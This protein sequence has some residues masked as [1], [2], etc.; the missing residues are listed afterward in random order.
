[1]RFARPL[2][3]LALLAAALMLFA[4]DSAPSGTPTAAG[5]PPTSA[6]TLAPAT[7]TPTAVPVAATAPAT[8]PTAAPPTRAPTTVLPASTSAFTTVATTV[9]PTP[10]RPLTIGGPGIGDG[11]FSKPSGIAVTADAVYV[12]DSDAARIQKFTLGGQFVWKA[13]TLGAE[14]GQL[15]A[16]GGIVVYNN[17]LYVAD[18]RN[19]RVSLFRADSGAFVRTIGVGGSDFDQLQSPSAVAL[20]AEGKLFVADRSNFRV[21]VYDREEK[22]LRM[23]GSGGGKEGQFGELGSNGVAISAANTLYATDTANDRIMT[24][25]FSGKYLSIFG[26]AG[27]TPGKL[28]RPLGLTIDKQGRLVVADTGNQRLSIFGADGSF[29]AVRQSPELEEPMYVA[30]GP[31]GALYVTDSKRAR[32]VILAP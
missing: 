16:P 26:G 25:E 14:P 18:A 30:T 12:A 24:F 27:N 15:N 20:D 23:S 21:Q 6:P 28:R 17:L 31:D 7:E 9:P 5:V 13:G 29:I 19:R 2:R 10:A 8:A 4:C 1:M 3:L 22:P 11:Q 32:V